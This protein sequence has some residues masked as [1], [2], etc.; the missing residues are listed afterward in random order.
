MYY[1]IQDKVVNEAQFIR[2]QRIDRSYVN[3]FPTVV[4]YLLFNQPKSNMYKI[5]LLNICIEEIVDDDDHVCLTVNLMY[6][7]YKRKIKI[8]Y[9]VQY[10]FSENQLKNLI[11]YGCYNVE[12]VHQGKVVEVQT[13]RPFQC[14][15]SQG[16]WWGASIT[17]TF[18]FVSTITSQTVF[19]L[20]I[21]PSS[22]PETPSPVVWSLYGTL[23]IQRTRRLVSSC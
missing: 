12:T 10:M 3:I 18:Q 22:S 1:Q 4:V 14:N 6:I 7:L 17:P 23:N 9:T 15:F 8:R 21:A 2:Q 19:C 5:E 11:T 13:T 16:N 20:I